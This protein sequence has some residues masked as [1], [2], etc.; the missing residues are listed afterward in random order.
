M[1]PRVMI[2]MTMSE[3]FIVREGGP[4]IPGEQA[5]LPISRTTAAQL[6]LNWRKYTKR[7]ERNIHEYGRAAD[8]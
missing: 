1:K 8:A 3:S 6:L 7:L 2:A 5:R 4:L